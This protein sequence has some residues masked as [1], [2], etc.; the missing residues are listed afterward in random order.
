MKYSGIG[1]QAVMEGV[2]MRNGKQYAVAVRKPDKEIV[3]DVKNTKNIN[4]IWHKIPII[5]GVVSFIESLVIGIGT[6]MY[7]AS[8]F[9]DD[10]EPVDKSKLSE[11]ELKKLE[12]KEKA[13]IGGTLVVSFA[14]AL[15]IFFALPYFIAMGLNHFSLSNAVI[16]FVEG[17]IRIAIFIGYIVVISRMEDIKRTFMYHGAEHKCINCVEAGLPLTVDNVRGATRFH[18]RCGT[19]FIFIVFI[20]SVFVFMFISFD[21]MWLKLLA[22]LLLIPVI[23]GISYEFIRLAGRYENKFVDIFS[24]PGLWLQRLTVM[25]PDDDMI[26]VGIASVEAVFDWQDFIEKN[27]EC[28]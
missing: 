19:S 26:E 17:I 14:L 22:R 1:G 2:M 9:E 20:I 7:S 4:D 28:F 25:E 11:E 10:E 18:K 24:K 15:G 27:K 23:A 6:L 8:F 3:V 21:N 12:R 13:E 16:A 5:R